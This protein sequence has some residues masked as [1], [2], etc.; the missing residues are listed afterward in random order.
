MLS[1]HVILLLSLLHLAFALRLPQLYFSNE[2]PLLEDE[3]MARAAKLMK[4]Y[5]MIDG[6][7]VPSHR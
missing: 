7:N 2:R 1:A 3:Y 5:P 4:T 6:H